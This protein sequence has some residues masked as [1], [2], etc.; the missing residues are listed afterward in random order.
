MWLLCLLFL[1][2]DLC[3]LSVFQPQG[4]RYSLAHFHTWDKT[5]V[6]STQKN[7]GERMT[8]GLETRDQERVDQNMGTRKRT[9]GTIRQIREQE[10]CLGC[11][12]SYRQ[13]RMPSNNHE[14][15]SWAIFMSKELTEK[16][17]ITACFHLRGLQGWEIPSQEFIA[18][19]VYLETM[20]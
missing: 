16:L 9:Q 2:T 20:R 1:P 11:V 19:K 8:G 3:W 18:S 5:G 14:D 17:Q 13:I 10:T 12:I 7:L 4:P 15:T 6:H